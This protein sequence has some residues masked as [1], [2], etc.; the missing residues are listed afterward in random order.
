MTIKEAIKKIDAH[1]L[2][3]GVDEKVNLTLNHQ[4]TKQQ[5]KDYIANTEDLIMTTLEIRFGILRTNEIKA[6][7]KNYIANDFDLD[8][9]EIEDFE[10]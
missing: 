10:I 4:C 2:Q 3:K 1:T 5:L 7:I 6:A 9:M 8:F